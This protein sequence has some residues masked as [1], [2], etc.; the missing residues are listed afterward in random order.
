MSVLNTPKSFFWRATAALLRW[1]GTL[2][3]RAAAR[4]SA[5]SLPKPSAEEC[6]L[7]SANERFRNCHVGQRCFVIAT[8]PS[9]K[10]QDIE[11]LAKEITFAM[12][13]FWHHEV[14]KK[15]QPTYYCFS[16]PAYFDGSEPMRESFRSL[17]SRV[18]DSTFF[19][20][21]HARSVIQSQHLL[22]AEKLYWVDFRDDLSN[23]NF[24]QG[25][26]DF[27]SFIPSAMS[28]SQLGIMAAIYMGCSPIYL[29]GHDH[30]WLSHQGEAGHFYNGHGGLEKHPE[31]KPML[32]DWSYKFIM[33]CQLG[34]WSGYENLLEIARRKGI[35]IVNATNG[36][37]LDVFER[38][39]YAKLLE[40]G[41]ATEI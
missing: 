23:R 9:L 22:P 17:T 41:N 36:G 25:E 2:L 13:G 16:D 5:R 40:D 29:L 14:V 32:S 27:T 12:S 6:R 38:A 34:L 30:D 4:A 31:F 15:W 3:T 39:D 19:V 21:L 26:I 37:F 24:A 11:P 18:Y 7:I 10:S 28:V 20:P 8:G 35:R 1:P 33:E